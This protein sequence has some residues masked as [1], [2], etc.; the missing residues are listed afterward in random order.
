MHTTPSTAE[1]AKTPDQTGG[2]AVAPE[3]ITRFL[4]LLRGIVGYGKTLADTFHQRAADADFRAFVTTRF[5][6]SDLNAIF[7]RIRRGLMLAAGLEAKLA[8]RAAAGRDLTPAPDRPYTP[9]RP[10]SG[11]KRRRPAVRHTNIVDLPLDRLPTAEQIAEE[12]RR[13]PVGAVL[14]DICRDLRP[15]PGA[16]PPGLVFRPDDH[17]G[18]ATISG[19]ARA[20][21]TGTYHVTITARNGVDRAAVQHLTLNFS[22]APAFTTPD[23]LS[24]NDGQYVRFTIRASGS[25]APAMSERGRLPAGLHFY[26]GHGIAVDPQLHCDAGREPKFVVTGVRRDEHRTAPARSAIGTIDWEL[27]GL[28]DPRS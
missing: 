22:Q 25:P 9:R 15:L 19:I 14:A 1:P 8:Q 23:H 7:A 16:L 28:L 13:R 12:L 5:H 20:G 24:V 2:S 10:G 6:T 26:A 4:F 27:G 11:S 3:A 21:L 17:N 18:T